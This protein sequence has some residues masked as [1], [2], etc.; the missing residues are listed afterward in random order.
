MT[1]CWK[2]HRGTSVFTFVR[3]ICVIVEKREPA[4]S[5]LWSGQ[6]TDDAEDCADKRKSRGVRT[7]AA[8][9]AIPT[10][11]ATERAN[12]I[13]PPLADVRPTILTIRPIDQDEEFLAR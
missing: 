6:F 11:A 10:A 4:R 7:D 8:T 12:L 2:S 9:A 3:L 13:E 1:P 5:R